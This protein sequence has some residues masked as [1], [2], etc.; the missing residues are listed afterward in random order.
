MAAVELLPGAPFDTTHDFSHYIF[1]KLIKNLKVGLVPNQNVVQYTIETGVTGAAGLNDY[2]PIGNLLLLDVNGVTCMAHFKY[3][4]I[5]E[6]NSTKRTNYNIFLYPNT[7]DI[8]PAFEN[9]YLDEHINILGILEITPGSHID[10]CERIDSPYRNLVYHFTYINQV[11][12]IAVNIDVTRR[13]N[14]V[15]D[16]TISLFKKN[17]RFYRNRNQNPVYRDDDGDAYHFFNDLYNDPVYYANS[18]DT[19]GENPGEQSLIIELMNAYN[20]QY[21]ALVGTGYPKTD[22]SHK[23]YRTTG[24]AR[25]KG[26]Y[27]KQGNAFKQNGHFGNVYDPV[28]AATALAQAQAAAAPPGL[29]P[30]ASGPPPGL[31]PP[32]A[33]PP[34][35]LPPGKAAAAAAASASPAHAAMTRTSGLGAAVN[36]TPSGLPATGPPQAKGTTTVSTQRRPLTIPRPDR[37][38]FGKKPPGYNG[39]NKLFG[40]DEITNIKIPTEIFEILKVYIL[41]I[42]QLKEYEINNIPIQCVKLEYN[43]K[44]NNTMM[45]IEFENDYILSYKFKDIKNVNVTKDIDISMIENVVNEYNKKIPAVDVK[46]KSE[47]IKTLGGYKKKSK[48]N[49]KNSKKSKKKSKKILRKK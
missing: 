39:G 8:D 10:Y 26:P 34:P 20:T 33:G 3:E 42:H 30:P 45:V 16:L 15:G 31:P 22:C 29:P 46:T 23:D 37:S 14:N 41:N 2:N 38:P 47:E 36:T 21:T 11:R 44:T 27:H 7:R 48:K 32:A 1:A 18:S 35:G 19:R 40:E 5:I 25:G 9:H 24:T 17:H 6:P 13:I 49:K 43:P 4:H 12:P 28:A